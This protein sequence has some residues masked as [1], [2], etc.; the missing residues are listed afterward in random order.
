MLGCKV[1]AHYQTVAR[2]RD[3]LKEERKE[4][5]R[6]TDRRG[7]DTKETTLRVPSS[8]SITSS[9]PSSDNKLSIRFTKEEGREFGRRVGTSPKSL[10]DVRWVFFHEF[11]LLRIAY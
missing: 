9:S 11:G 2:G 7:E 1:Y 10:E 5:R 8:C 6:Y 3:F 4:M